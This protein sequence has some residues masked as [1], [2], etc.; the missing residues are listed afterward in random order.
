MQLECGPGCVWFW[1]AT[2]QVWTGVQL[3]TRIGLS[4]YFVTPH[5]GIITGK[6]EHTHNTS[7][8]LISLLN[9]PHNQLLSRSLNHIKPIDT[10]SYCCAVNGNS[11]GISQH[12]LLKKIQQSC[13]LCRKYIGN[14]SWSKLKQVTGLV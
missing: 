2:L 3:Y 14:S 1:P 13:T 11:Y 8:F 6:W 7:Y 12:S 5:D 10:Y 9:L 4:Y